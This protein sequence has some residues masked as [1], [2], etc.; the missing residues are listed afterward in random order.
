MTD[1]SAGGGARGLLQGAGEHLGPLQGHLNL[2]QGAERRGQEFLLA[3]P[4]PSR[5]Q[6]M[7]LL[8]GDESG[9]HLGPLQSHLSPLK[10]GRGQEMLLRSPQPSRRQEMLSPP[11]RQEEGLSPCR[12]QEEV[13]SPCSGRRGSTNS[14]LSFC[15]PR[16]IT[17]GVRGIRALEEWCRRSTQGYS[18]VHVAN[19]SSSWRDGRAFCAL[20]NRHRP[21]L[22]N[23]DGLVGTDW[24]GNCSLAFSVAEKDLGIPQLLDVEDLVTVISPDKFSVMTYLAQFYH[25]FSETDPD[26]G[27]SS[28]QCSSSEEDSPLRRT[29]PPVKR[30]G[31]VL[32]LLNLKQRR[33]VSWHGRGR[34]EVRLPC[35]PVEQENPFLRPEMRGEDELVRRLTR[36]SEVKEPVV[37][38]RAQPRQPGRDRVTRSLH[39]QSSLLSSMWSSG[40]QGEDRV[41]VRRRPHSSLGTSH[42]YTPYTGR[43]QQGTEQGSI[44]GERA[45]AARE[46]RRR[47]SEEG[48]EFNNQYNQNQARLRARSK[49]DPNVNRVKMAKQN[50]SEIQKR[51]RLDFFP[52]KP[53]PVADS[54]KLDIFRV[55]PPLLPSLCDSMPSSAATT[56]RQRGTNRLSR[57]NLA[58]LQGGHS[59]QPDKNYMLAKFLAQGTRAEDKWV[60]WDR[61]LATSIAYWHKRFPSISELQAVA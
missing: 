26:S 9:V 55:Q 11:R 29:D 40:G 39:I 47:R 34:L 8:D 41:R 6:A 24:A 23:Y 19:M 35:L 4:L 44:I 25:K 2:F 43:K 32:S 27:F 48:V 22:L 49:K 54:L 28:L 10:E 21:D 17:M 3:S 36:H 46:R 31:A 60:Q 56:A 5:R 38:M 15:S 12:G 53:P 51:L 58:Q 16:R 59:G 52:V 50:I 33:P 1:Q 18:G 13:T 14:D 45:L 30:E 61:Q 20:I 42:M 57:T 7:I 37:R